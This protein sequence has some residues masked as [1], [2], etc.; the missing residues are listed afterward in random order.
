MHATIEIVVSFISQLNWS[1][2]D[3]STKR[4]EEGDRGSK[5]AT[6]ILK[7]HLAPLTF[8]PIFLLYHSNKRDIKLHNTDWSNL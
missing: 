2:L 7:I 1:T 4:V 6:L 3:Q 8:S 5:N